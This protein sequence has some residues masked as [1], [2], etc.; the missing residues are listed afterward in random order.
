LK[1][2]SI[3]EA[4]AFAILLRRRL[5]RNQLRRTSDAG[6]WEDGEGLS[7]YQEIRVQG[8]RGPGYQGNRKIGGQGIGGSGKQENRRSGYQVEGGFN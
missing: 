7:G 5:C 3:P 6:C 2:C 1:N 4:S 8:N